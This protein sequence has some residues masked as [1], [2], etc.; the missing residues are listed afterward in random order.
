MV[1]REELALEAN[2]YLLNQLDPDL[3]II[4]ASMGPP[5]ERSG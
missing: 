1:S 4:D 2:A 5:R 3:I